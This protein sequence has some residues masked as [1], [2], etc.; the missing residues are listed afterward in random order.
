STWSSYSPISQKIVGPTAALAAP[1]ESLYHVCRKG[2][3]SLVATNMSFV[4]EKLS[5]MDYNY[6]NQ[7]II[8]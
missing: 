4:V 3:Y 8:L 7:L 5:Q 1:A 2:R 6:N